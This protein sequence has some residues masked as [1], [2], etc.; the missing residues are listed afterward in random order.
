MTAPDKIRVVQCEFVQ[1]GP[2]ALTSMPREFQQVPKLSLPLR[3]DANNMPTVELLE[4]PSTSNAH[5]TLTSSTCDVDLLCMPPH[6]N[7]PPTL[8]KSTDVD[9]LS[10]A[11]PDTSADTSTLGVDTSFELG[12]FLKSTGLNEQQAAECEVKLTKAW[13]DMALLSDL[14]ESDLRNTVGLPLGAS[15]RISK[16]LA[17]RKWQ[18]SALWQL[19]T[20]FG[21]VVKAFW[22]RSFGL[23]K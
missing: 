19:A 8:K 1:Q 17:A 2:I 10:M 13:V 20:A 23:G 15:M 6:P 16:E 9:L 11:H 7:P 22:V 4:G 14:S 5:P 3:S 21:Q 12:C 18:K